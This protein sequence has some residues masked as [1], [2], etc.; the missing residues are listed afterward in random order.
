[1]RA[2]RG[3]VELVAHSTTQAV[4]SLLEGDTATV[5][6][7]G[8]GRRP[9][10]KRARK[11]T[12]VG[13]IRLA[14]G[15]RLSTRHR[16]LDITAGIEEAAV[17][18]AMHELV[19][20]GAD[21]IAASEAFGVE[22]ARGEWL[23]LKI[24]AEMGVPA[25]AGHELTGLYGLEMR[26]V[27]AALNGSI[28]ATALK[29]ARL[30]QEAAD[31][32][33]PGV[34]LL[35][36][37]GD[38]G[39]VNLEV[40]KRHPLLTAFSGPAASVA[41]ALQRVH[42]N[43]AVV[44]EVGGTSSNVAVI[45]GG[46][47][48]LS[49]VR[50]LDHVTCVRSLDVR[51]VGVAGGSLVRVAKRMGGLRVADVGPRSAHIV[52]LPYACFEAQE[53]IDGSAARLVA[54]RTGDPADYLVL[55]TDRGRR[56]GLTLTCA[57]NALGEVPLNAYA[58]GDP[59]AARSAF[60]VAGTFLGM[61]GQTLARKV[62]E[63][64]TAKVAAVVGEGIAEQDLRSPLVVG[65]GGGAGALVPAVAR[66]FATAYEIPPDAE[67]ISSLGD[68]Q[69]AVRVEIERTLARASSEEVARVHADAE[70]AALR[71]GAAPGTIQLESRS[72]PE[73]GALRVTAYGAVSLQSGSSAIGA[74]AGRAERAARS[75]LAGDL[76]LVFGNEFFFV[77]VSGSGDDRSFAVV[78]RTGAVAFEG[79]G[80]VISGSGSEVSARLDERIP[81]LVRHY[82]PVAVAPAVR[83]IRGPRLVDLTLMSNPDA[84]REAALA[85][86]ALAY[87]EEVVALLTRD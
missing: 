87:D 47:P 73:R 75:V 9:D 22:D 82:G 56:I 72:V 86:C 69:S 84:A 70:E 59:A 28:L 50:V 49:Y 78:D 33:A 46:R 19:E 21:V 66:A 57:A 30:V 53:E 38:G 34:P 31:R 68:A 2:E 55:E 15:R 16:F 81:A 40:M 76:H 1:A 62:L 6:V 11:R 63:V 45:K 20:E 39:V 13:D 60:A 74:D 10:L 54:P 24:A 12:E 17:R 80:K 27:T 7:L 4:N 65:L 58:A 44:I 37:R 8:M 64:A 35:V 26:T 48:V 67:V 42:I 51:V 23:A 77:Y 3:P 83:V 79:H 41:G 85:E 5:G 61:D 43:D 52:G 14:P 71:A 25:C 36:M 32:K 29:T 18:H